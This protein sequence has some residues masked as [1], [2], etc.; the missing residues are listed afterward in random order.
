MQ[1]S[2]A[3]II[4]FSIVTTI[5]LGG[6][7][8][9]TS[10][11][12]GPRQKVQ[13]ELDTKKSI[14]GAVMEVQKTDDVLAIYDARI[15]SLVVDI[16]GNEVPVKSDTIET[17][18]KFP[19]QYGDAYSSRGYTHL[20]MNPFYNGIWVQYRQ[21]SS[22]VDGWGSITTPRNTLATKAPQL[23]E[24]VLNMNSIILQ[25]SLLFLNRVYFLESI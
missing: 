23:P 25:S 14:L 8:S 1:Q 15:E 7:L 16:E 9:I 21:R 10:V 5:I 20:D 6:L 19:L 11:G 22:L 17:R 12:L 18:Y 3:Y 2:N 4:V 13:V 24:S